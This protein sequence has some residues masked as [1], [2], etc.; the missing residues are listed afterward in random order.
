MVRST[1]DRCEHLTLEIRDL[2]QMRVSIS[3]APLSGKGKER[4]WLNRKLAE[5]G[6]QIDQRQKILGA[7]TSMSETAESPAPGRALA[8]TNDRRRAIPSH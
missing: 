5:I 7:L 8:T 1:A 6:R 4:Y 3:Q 2:E